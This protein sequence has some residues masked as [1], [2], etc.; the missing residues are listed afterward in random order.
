MARARGRQG[1]PES[2]GGRD[3]E[4]FMSSSV[5]VKASRR[6]RVLAFSLAFVSL[7]RDSRSVKDEGDHC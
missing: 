3:A 7:R 1:A 4:S 2:P 5:T 6:S